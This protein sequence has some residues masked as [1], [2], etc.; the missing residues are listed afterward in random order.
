MCLMSLVTTVLI[1]A[2]SSWSR[3]GPHRTSGL[4]TSD[5][6]AGA[7]QTSQHGGQSYSSLCQVH[8][9]CYGQ[10]KNFID[11]LTALETYLCTYKKKLRN[12]SIIYSVNTF[13]TY[14]VNAQIP[15]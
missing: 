8:T 7:Q 12:I 9:S 4:P 6:W 10:I 11:K 14:Q 2:V 3:G 15:V 5:P 13:K 1:A